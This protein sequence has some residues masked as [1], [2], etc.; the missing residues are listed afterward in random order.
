MSD[1]DVGHDDDEWAPCTFV[2]YN[3]DRRVAKD[4]QGRARWI[5]GYAPNEPNPGNAVCNRFDPVGSAM[6]RLPRHHH[7]PH[8]AFDAT[9]V[10]P[11][12][13]YVDMIL[14]CPDCA[15]SGT[16]PDGSR[17]PSCWGWRST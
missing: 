5:M 16:A 9:L 4:G 8:V 7:G 3:G 17:C 14:P 15:D 13:I 2:V 12:G 6:C 11:S 10:V 1:L